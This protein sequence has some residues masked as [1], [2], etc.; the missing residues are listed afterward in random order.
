MTS[1]NVRHNAKYLDVQLLVEQAFWF[2]NEN[3]AVIGSARTLKE[4]VAQLGVVPSA[5]IAEHARRGDFSRWVAEVFHD[6]TLASDIR[7][8]ERRFELGHIRNLADFVAK[9]IQE[10]YEFSP[11]TIDGAGAMAA[12]EEVKKV[13]AGAV[14]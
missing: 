4:F 14:A 10:R 9:L 2:T 1:P 12:R 8:A 6:S 11:E 5:V 13:A 7:K 3:R